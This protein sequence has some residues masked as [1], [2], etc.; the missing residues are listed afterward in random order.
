MRVLPHNMELP[1]EIVAI[2]REYSKPRFKYFR[3]YKRM[4]QWTGRERWSTLKKL[5]DENTLPYVLQCEEVFIKCEK[6]YHSIA[7][8]RLDSYLNLRLILVEIHEEHG[9]PFQER[10]PRNGIQSY[11]IQIG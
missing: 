8:T 7:L 9:Y 2:I 11:P 3:E 5:L 4:L 1:E 6:M 10:G